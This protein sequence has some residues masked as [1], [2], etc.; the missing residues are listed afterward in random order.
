MV[1]KGATTPKVDTT[2]NG[3]NAVA[4]ENVITLNNLTAGAREI[5]VSFAVVKRLLE[6]D[7]R[8]KGDIHNRQKRRR[9]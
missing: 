3:K 8:R 6:P 4:G 5:C 9:R 1:N 7:R 2:K